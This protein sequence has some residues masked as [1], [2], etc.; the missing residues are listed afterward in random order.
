V[1]LMSTRKIVLAVL[2]AVLVTFAIGAYAQ[3]TKNNKDDIY[4]DL[5]AFA[6]ILEKVQNYYVEEVDMHELMHTAI[7]EMLSTLD[8]HSQYLGGLDYEDLMVS[9]RGEFGG[10]GIYI[11]FRDNYPTVISPID[12][13][14]ADRAGIRGGDRIT[15]IEG[16]GHRRLESRQGRWLPS[17]R[18]RI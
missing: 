14:P 8:P 6:K 4:H 16:A 18:A 2:S 1:K 9:T 5:E 12:D 3:S 15:Q 11:S 13:T 10:L 17:R 7:T